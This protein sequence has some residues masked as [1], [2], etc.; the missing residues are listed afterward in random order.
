MTV[1]PVCYKYCNFEGCVY[2]LAKF[3]YETHA[4]YCKL[5][6]LM[7]QRD[8]EHTAL[9]SQK[10]NFRNLLHRTQEHQKMSLAR[11]SLNMPQICWRNEFSETSPKG[12]RIKKL[13]NLSASSNIHFLK[14]EHISENM[15]EKNHI[16]IFCIALKQ[17]Y[18]NRHLDL[19]ISDT[20]TCVSLPSTSKNLIKKIPNVYYSKTYNLLYEVQIKR[21][22]LKWLETYLY[23]LGKQNYIHRIARIWSHFFIFGILRP[24]KIDCKG[25]SPFENWEH[26]FVFTCKKW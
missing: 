23:H 11:W 12:I 20:F 21:M 17:N 6:V 13:T 2:F 1:L 10:N 22:K 24:D 3:K 16:W 8:S 15:T 9:C 18:K 14:T 26:Q 19:L 25:C 4:Q 5:N 7:I